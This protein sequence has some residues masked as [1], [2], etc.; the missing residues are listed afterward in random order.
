VDV[1]IDESG[2]GSVSLSCCACGL[3][4]DTSANREVLFAC[5]TSLS[6]MQA[7]SGTELFVVPDE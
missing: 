4:P 1:D 6:A 3:E 5:R 7:G 2:T